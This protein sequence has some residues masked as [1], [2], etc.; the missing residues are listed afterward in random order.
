MVDNLPLPR[1]RYFIWM[2]AFDEAGAS[3]MRWHPAAPLD[4][5]GSPRQPPPR[6]VMLLSPVHVSARWDARG[7]DLPVTVQVPPGIGGVS[8]LPPAVS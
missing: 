2:G 7:E 5:E 6:G 8:S 1:G 3:R 4:V